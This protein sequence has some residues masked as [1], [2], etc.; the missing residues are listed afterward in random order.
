MNRNYK[1]IINNIIKAE[2]NE[3]DIE[4]PLDISIIPNYMGI[5]LVAVDSIEWTE[6]EDGQLVSLTINFIPEEK[7]E[8]ER[9]GVI[10]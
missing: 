7:E 4:C 9:E 1:R 10:L 6:Q 3:Q 8:K 2:E 5:N